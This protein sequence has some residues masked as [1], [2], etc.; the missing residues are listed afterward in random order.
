MVKTK[1][2]GEKLKVYSADGFS[3]ANSWIENSI[4]T[5][6]ID[7]ADIVVLP[8]GSDWNPYW[9]SEPKGRYTFFNDGIDI[10]QMKVMLEAMKNGKLIIGICRGMQGVHIAAGGKLIQDVTG[11]RNGPHTITDVYSHEVVGV[12]S[13][14]HQMVDLNSLPFGSYDLI[15]ASSVKISKTYLDGNNNELVN[16]KGL[17]YKDDADFEEPEVVYYAN[18]H[19]LGFQYHPELM[20]GG[21]PGL[22]YSNNVIKTIIESASFLFNYS[23]TYKYILELE[24]KLEAIQTSNLKFYNNLFNEGKTETQTQLA[25]PLKAEEQTCECKIETNEKNWRDHIKKW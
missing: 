8:G 9:Y 1:S 25:L 15:A 20:S 21:H 11:H 12:N 7:D 10:R 5:N 4:D 24:D 19:A 16:K 18:I 2:S 17:L 14:H 23:E 13:M 6:R 3:G 22:K